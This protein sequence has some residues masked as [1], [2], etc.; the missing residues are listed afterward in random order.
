MNSLIK[1]LI[2]ALFMYLTLF[3]FNG[4][5]NR[6]SPPENVAKSITAIEL[7]A[8]DI[9]MHKSEIL[10][11]NLGSNGRDYRFECG[12]SQGS[13]SL[14][15]IDSICLQN[16][17]I[18]FCIND[19]NDVTF[20]LKGESDFFKGQI[21]ERKLFFSRSNKPNTIYEDNQIR[22]KCCEKIAKKI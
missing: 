22:N 19:D 3:C 12:K 14:K 17:I 9:I 10:L 13:N 11:Q 5:S 16:S 21:I 18:S 20:F 4:L 2:L 7:L 1:F 8:D 15:N 6:C